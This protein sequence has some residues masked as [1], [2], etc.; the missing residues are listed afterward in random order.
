MD[1]GR[2]E[3]LASAGFVRC[4]SCVGHEHEP[5]CRD[6]SGRQGAALTQL[7]FRVIYSSC[8]S[9]CCGLY[10]EK[11]NLLR[12][13]HNSSSIEHKVLAGNVSESQEEEFIYISIIGS[14]SVTQFYLFWFRVWVL[15]YRVTRTRWV[16]VTWLRS[17]V[18]EH[19]LD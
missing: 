15:L 19:W 8:F 10:S 5:G 7:M 16:S 13:D 2:A 9:V 11:W 6:Q 1:L 4:A 18:W 12:N 3:P 17:S 14:E